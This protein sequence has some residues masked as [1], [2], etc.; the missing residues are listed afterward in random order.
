[1]TQ[2]SESLKKAKAKYYQK[3][4]NDP[5]YKAKMQEKGKQYYQENQEKLKE[6]FKTYYN[7]HKETINEK[8][9]LKN[10]TKKLNNVISKLESINIEELAKILITKK[11]T[12]LL[13]FDD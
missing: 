8:I 9:K 13:E 12:K 5:D 11:K 10:D 3:I 6:K 2:S 4:K 7:E 1:M